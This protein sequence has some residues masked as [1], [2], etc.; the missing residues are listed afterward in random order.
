MK[1]DYVIGAMD[2]G[3]AERVVSLLANYFAEN[4]HKVRIITFYG[5]DAYTYHPSIERIRFHKK[6]IINYATFRGFFS[7]LSFYFRKKNRPDVISSHIHLVGFATILPAKLYNIGITVSEHFNHFHQRRTRAK[8]FLWNFLY[9]F[10]DAVTVLT[11]FDIPFFQKKNKNVVVMPNPSS[12]TANANPP[13]D[14]DKTILAVGSLN[15]YDHKGFDT[16]IKIADAVLK[17][18]PQW[19]I[20]IVGNGDIGMKF[21]KN[22]V[23]EYQVEDKVIFTGFRNDVKE[24]M[25][26]SEIFVLSSRREG[27]PMVLLEAMSQGMACISFDCITG[28]S[29]IITDDVDGI[30]VEDQNTEEMITKLDMLIAD[31]DLRRKL[32][33]KAVNSIDKFSMERIGK[34]WE[35][36]FQEILEKDT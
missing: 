17:D 10:A 31:E 34:K 26:N 15:R 24:M 13:E 16:L 22:K 20:K 25:A 28:P 9:R 21:L 4:G 7:L 8:W 1:I 3:G 23:K 35:E 12:F 29:D 36:L 14:R 27:L 18:R 11:K 30:L 5:G 33:A 19:K 32:G 6:F 2:G